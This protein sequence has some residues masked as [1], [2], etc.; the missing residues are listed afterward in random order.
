MDVND[1]CPEI[2]P[3]SVTL[4]PVPVLTTDPLVTFTSADA[5]SGENANIRYV[6]TQITEV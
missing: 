6:L 3:T 2:S 1:N 4:N 5:D